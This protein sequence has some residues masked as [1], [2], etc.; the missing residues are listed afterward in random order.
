MTTG[1]NYRF[2]SLGIFD[3]QV[4]ILTL[5][6][7]SLDFKAQ[8][9]EETRETVIPALEVFNRNASDRLYPHVKN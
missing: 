6:H 9:I 2:P 1:K 5:D 3:F 8:E 7:I 4:R